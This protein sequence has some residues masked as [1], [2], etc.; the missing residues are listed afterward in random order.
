MSDEG[1][2]RLG[3]A[4][5]QVLD[6]VGEI[7]V[8]LPGI[9]DIAARSGCAMAAKVDGD[10]LESGVRQPSRDRV[11]L[12]GRAGRA[13]GDEDGPIAGAGCRRVA[14]IGEPGPVA[15]LETRKLGQTVGL[16][17]QGAVEDGSKRRRRLQGT[18]EKDGEHNGRNADEGEQRNQEIEKDHV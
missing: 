14:P 17:L 5:P 13:V 12:S 8:E 16:D 2:L 15:R 6:Q 10:R 1:E 9:G 7:V 3:I 4:T 18:R 11:H